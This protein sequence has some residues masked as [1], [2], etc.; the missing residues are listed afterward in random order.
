LGW[1]RILT[2]ADFVTV[3]C[4]STALLNAVAEEWMALSGNTKNEAF[5]T[6]DGCVKLVI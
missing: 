2:K 1:D 3:Q 5:N 4:Q 6:Q